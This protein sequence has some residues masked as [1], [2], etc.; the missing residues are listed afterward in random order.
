[1]RIITLLENRQLNEA[2][3]QN[4]DPKKLKD[5]ADKFEPYFIDEMLNQGKTVT[6]D[7][8]KAIEQLKNIA[9]QMQP[10]DKLPSG[11]IKG[12]LLK[13]IQVLYGNGDAKNGLVPRFIDELESIKQRLHNVVDNCGELTNE[14]ISKEFS[15]KVDTQRGA[16]QETDNYAGINQQVKKLLDYISVRC[17]GLKDSF[18]AIERDIKT[19]FSKAKQSPDKVGQLGL[20]AV[21]TQ[22]LKDMNSLLDDVI[23]LITDIENYQIERSRVVNMSVIQWAY[24]YCIANSA[25][26]IASGSAS[27]TKSMTS[28]GG[29]RG[30]FSKEV[31]DDPRGN[32]RQMVNELYEGLEFFKDEMN[33]PPTDVKTIIQYFAPQIASSLKYNKDSAMD[34]QKNPFIKYLVSS[35]VKLNGESMANGVITLQGMWVEGKTKLGDVWDG[36]KCIKPWLYNASLLT[37]EPAELQYA[38]QMFDTLATPEKAKAVYGVTESADGMPVSPSRFYVNRRVNV[39]SLQSMI[40]SEIR[41]SGQDKKF[42]HKDDV[43]ISDSVGWLRQTTEYNSVK[44]Q[45]Q[46]NEPSREHEGQGSTDTETKSSGTTRR[47]SNTVEGGISEKE[48]RNSKPD[49]ERALSNLSDRDKRLVGGTLKKLAKQA[50]IELDDMT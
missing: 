11:D 24:Y 19:A 8:V 9:L 14:Q 40:E 30:K 49:I 6:E 16:V 10:T 22:N 48:L 26:A 17:K 33:L 27:G 4:V 7:D 50:G 3:P 32:V 13:S 46:S 36:K 5:I 2:G 21:T 47:A 18:L 29:V 37:R 41:P 45:E 43:T 23:Q 1:M 31:L 34:M 12:K 35:P 20:D 38:V 25:D 44:Q 28:S 15:L 42:N 39:N